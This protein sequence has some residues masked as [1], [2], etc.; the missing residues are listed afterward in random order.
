MTKYPTGSTR[1]GFMKT[2]LGAI[3]LLGA[4]LIPSD[5]DN[6]PGKAY[7]FFDCPAPRQTIRKELP[8][9]RKAVHTPESLDLDLRDGGSSGFEHLLR[10]EYSG[11]NLEAARELSHI[12]NQ[13][14]HDPALYRENGEF[15]GR[16]AYRDN[17]RW[18]FIEPEGIFSELNKR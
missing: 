12:D 4:S 16:I 5:Y 17:G 1:R 9:I 18:E 6:K 13:A 10:A 2:G 11:S 14:V 8:Y 7:G 3:A 15:R